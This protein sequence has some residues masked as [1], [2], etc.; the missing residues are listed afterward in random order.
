MTKRQRE[1]SK[2]VTKR[3]FS[4][5]EM[6]IVLAIIGVI[7]GGVITGQ[8]LLRKSE[9]NEAVVQKE[10]YVSAIQQF[11]SQYGALPGDM[12]KATKYWGTDPD[13]CPTHTNRVL[14]KETCNGNGDGMMR[15]T[16]EL[17]RVWQ[18]L[19]NAG[20]LLE[21]AFTGVAGAG[22]ASD[23]V[24]GVNSPRGTV[25]GSAWVAFWPGATDGTISSANFYLNLNYK[26]ILMMGGTDGTG[27]PSQ[28]VFTV[29]EAYG[30]DEKY[31]DGLSYN[32]SIIAGRHQGCTTAADENDMPNTYDFDQLGEQCVPIYRDAF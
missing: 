11:R 15:G 8:N 4:L 7:V 18:Q 32:G 28:S 13:G 9:V 1:S 22:G 21:E 10:K 30:I 24:S 14:K 16:D 26:H 3:G 17:F 31:D 25:D 5:V 19:A 2:H 29:R 6:A 27:V 12:R 20:L 23:S